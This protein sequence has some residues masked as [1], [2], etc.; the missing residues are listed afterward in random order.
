MTLEQG[1]V[2]GYLLTFNDP[3]ILTQLDALEENQP[4]R[5]PAEN[6]HQRQSIP[7]Y[8]SDK[9]FIQNAG[10]YVMSADRINSLKGISI[11]HQGW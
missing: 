3:M 11:N 5:S 7:I 9:I 8:T 10:V 2:E 1:W 6:Y 4:W